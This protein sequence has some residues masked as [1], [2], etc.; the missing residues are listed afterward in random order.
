MT[1]YIA[2]L[3]FV[4]LGLGASL[5]LL[6]S[7]DTKVETVQSDSCLIEPGRDLLECEAIFDGLN[8]IDQYANAVSFRESRV[9]YADLVVGRRYRILIRHREDDLDATLMSAEGIGGEITARCQSSDR[10]SKAL[11]PSGRV[12]INNRWT[13]RYKHQVIVVIL[14]DSTFVEAG[15]FGDM[16]KKYPPLTEACLTNHVVL[17]GIY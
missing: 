10:V 12:P 4:L 2:P 11:V 7:V 15:Y 13:S 3:L 14:R 9:S 1:K 5:S 16:K 8:F 17:M 6:R